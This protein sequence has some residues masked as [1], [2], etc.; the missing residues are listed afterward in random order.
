[1]LPRHLPPPMRAS[2]TRHSLLKAKEAAQWYRDNTYGPID[3]RH[4]TASDAAFRPTLPRC[5]A[6]CR[7]ITRLFIAPACSYARRR[8]GHAPAHRHA[9]RVIDMDNVEYHTR[10]ES[11]STAKRRNT[12]GDEYGRRRHASPAAA[13]RVVRRGCVP[14]AACPPRACL[15]YALPLPEGIVAGLTMRERH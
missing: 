6:F 11:I 8:V 5:A 10:R 2:A 1:M 14:A 13:P 3:G 15:P 4:A 7:V 12:L 9:V